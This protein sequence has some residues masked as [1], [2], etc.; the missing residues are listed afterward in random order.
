[1]NLIQQKIPESK[2]NQASGQ[3]R[4][5]KSAVLG[6]IATRLSPSDATAGR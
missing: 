3:L 5:A 4:T 6:Q 2:K 1:M